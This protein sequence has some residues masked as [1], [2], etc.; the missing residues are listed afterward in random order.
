MEALELFSRGGRTTAQRPRERRVG[1]DAPAKHHMARL[2]IRRDKGIHVPAVEDVSVVCHGKRRAA[3]GLAVCPLPRD[4]LVAVTLD[5]R[6]NDELRK[7]M[8]QVH[9]EDLLVFFVRHHADPRLHRNRDGRFGAHPL[10][11]RVELLEI[12]QKTR[13]PA[14]GHDRPRRAAQVEVDLAETHAREHLRAPYEPLRVVREHLRHHVQAPVIHRVELRHRTLAEPA[15]QMRGR[16]K[17]RVVAVERAEALRMHR[18]EGVPGKP[19]HGGERQNHA[20]PLV[21]TSRQ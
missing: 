12:P 9:G 8:P 6:V 10:Q 11:K 18:A 4:T 13:A 16:E 17:R 7:R 20:L 3:Q 2:G 5:A 1:E 15:A 21:G 19:L 14:L